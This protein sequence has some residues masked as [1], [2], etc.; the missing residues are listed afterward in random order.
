M[1]LPSYSPDLNPIEQAFAKLKA[2][3]RSAAARRIPEL[4]AAIRHAFT[5][6]TPQECRN[7]LAAAGYEDDLAVDT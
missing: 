7:C 2:L 4:W 6:F 3:L 1:Y 5:H